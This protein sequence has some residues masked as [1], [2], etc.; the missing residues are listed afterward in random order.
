MLAFTNY[1]LFISDVVMHV[2]PNPK[3]FPERFKLWVNLV[4][5]GLESLSE[6]DI[7]ITKRICDIHFIDEHRVRYKRLSALAVPTLHLPSKL[8]SFN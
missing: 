1:H 5:E 7:Y 6:N 3:R 8:Y 2:F 4:D